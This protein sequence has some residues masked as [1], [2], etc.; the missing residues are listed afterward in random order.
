MALFLLL[1]PF[2]QIVPLVPNRSTDPDCRKLTAMGYLPQSSLG[3]AQQSRGLA[4]SN[5]QGLL[6]RTPGAVGIIHACVA[7]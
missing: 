1:N 5:K 2:F 3:N 6:A 4:G 7:R